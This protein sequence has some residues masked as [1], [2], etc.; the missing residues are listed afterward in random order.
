MS[1]PNRLKQSTKDLRTI[2]TFI[3]DISISGL[4][5][6]MVGYAILTGERKKMI[7]F[8]ISIDFFQKRRIFST[9][10]LILTFTGIS[11]GSETYQDNPCG[12]GAYDFAGGGPVHICA[13]F[14]GL[15]YLVVLGKRKLIH[16]EHHNMVNV[17]FGTGVLWFGWFA[18]NGGSEG[19]ANPRAAMACTVLLL[20][21]NWHVIKKND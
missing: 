12:A 4:G 15:A 21:E 5:P 1:V 7:I 2:K 9:W 13:G 16:A 8:E 6:L 19:A 14:S 20:K 3:F 11:L 17:M 18:F 10:I